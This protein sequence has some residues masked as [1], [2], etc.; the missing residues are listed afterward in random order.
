MGGIH[1]WITLFFI[2]HWIWGTL[3]FGLHKFVLGVAVATAFHEVGHLIAGEMT[4]VPSSGICLGPFSGGYAWY[5]SAER[6]TGILRGKVV[7]PKWK[8]FPHSYTFPYPSTGWTRIAKS[9]GGPIGSL[10]AMV[11]VV[12]Y[13]RYFSFYPWPDQHFYHVM[14]AVYHSAFLMGLT[15]MGLIGVLNVVPRRGEAALVGGLYRFLP[16][17]S[18]R[19]ERWLTE[20]ARSRVLSDGDRIWSGVVRSRRGRRWNGKIR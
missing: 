20:R 16:F 15:A 8:W 5:W 17:K 12:V 4:P 18:W 6:R 10:A 2:H 3:V 7:R 1:A 19:V 9:A 14:D 13:V 11:V